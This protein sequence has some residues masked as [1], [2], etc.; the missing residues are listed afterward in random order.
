MTGNINVSLEM[1]GTERL[2]ARFDGY[3]GKLKG[4]LLT[5]MDTIVNY[6]VL[7]CQENKLSG[8]VLHARTGT[9]R[10]SI[11]GRFGEAS[12]SVFGEV[13]SRAD[14]NKPLAYAAFW[15]KG[16]I[17]DVTVKAHVRKIA[18]GDFAGELTPVRSFV[19]HINQAP[20]PFLKPTRDENTG[21]I[22]EQLQHA[23][24]STN[25]S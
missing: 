20:R 6:L 18:L 21:Y 24:S 4:N 10:R 1:V 23:V 16:F 15:E 8:Q 3:V 22:K 17:G 14:G 5:A 12:G 7:Y 2:V 11:Q 19:R 13:T 25:A 9:L